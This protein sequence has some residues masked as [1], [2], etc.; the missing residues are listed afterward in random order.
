MKHI[1]HIN[2][3]LIFEYDSSFFK[4][5]LESLSHRLVAPDGRLND[6]DSNT[7]IEMNKINAEIDTV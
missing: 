2:F 5:K 6:S 3:S 4:Q 1:K 7:R